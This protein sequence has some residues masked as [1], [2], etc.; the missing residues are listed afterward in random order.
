MKKILAMLLAALMLLSLLAACSSDISKGDAEIPGGTTEGGES[1][2]DTTPFSNGTIVLNAG[3][4]F[5]ILYDAEGLVLGVEGMDEYYKDFIDYL[6]DSS[7]LMG[8]SCSDAISELIKTCSVKGYLTEVG[9]V[10]IKQAHGSQLPGTKFLESI[11]NAA[12]KA[13]DV[14]KIDAALVV[15]TAEQLDANGY[16]DLATAK[17][18]VE[19]FVGVESLTNFDGTSEPVGGVYA[20][21]IGYDD[22]EENVLVNAVTGSVEFGVMDELISEQDTTEETD[23]AETTAPAEIPEDGTTAPAES[24]DAEA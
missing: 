16:I 13:L 9:Y 24:N 19:K 5:S 23:A 21:T 2:T 14:A 11:Q 20:F 4:A 22:I 12:Q 10:V 15:I 6:Y 17:V 1:A 3:V 18:L 8:L 7:I